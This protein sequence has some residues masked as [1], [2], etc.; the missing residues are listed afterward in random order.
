MTNTA[1]CWDIPQPPKVGVDIQ[2]QDFCWNDASCAAANNSQKGTDRSIKH[3]KCRNCL[4]PFGFFCHMTKTDCIKTAKVFNNICSACTD[5][6]VVRP[7]WNL[8]V[9]N[10]GTPI[11]YS[12]VPVIGNKHVDRQYPCGRFPQ[13]KDPNATTMMM[14]QPQ[15]QEYYEQPTPDQIKQHLLQQKQQNGST[16]NNDKSNAATSSIKIEQTNNKNLVSDAPL[17]NNVKSKAIIASQKKP[18]HSNKNNKNDDDDEY[19]EEDKLL[20]EG[21][22]K[23][24]GKEKRESGKR[25]G[26]NHQSSTDDELEN[27]NN[28]KNNKNKNNKKKQDDFSSGD[29]D[30]DSSDDEDQPVGKKKK[31]GKKPK[32]ALETARNIPI[33]PKKAELQMQI[34]D[35]LNGNLETRTAKMKKLQE[36][37][38]DDFKNAILFETTYG[39]VEAQTL[40]QAVHEKLAAVRSAF[41][42]HHKGDNAALLLKE[43]VG[44]QCILCGEFR[45]GSQRRLDQEAH[46][47]LRQQ[48]AQR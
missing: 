38:A 11:I 44:L 14:Q 31:K 32:V 6:V 43:A 16:T 17:Q 19:D 28:K 34:R 20:L 48:G 41:F 10:N 26:R 8:Q 7:Q 25:R 4:K 12:S 39:A 40:P 23:K 33:V 21:E 37:N 5:P 3:Q 45:I 15:P 30:Q 27:N 9:W 29:D 46:R 1:R 13:P 42:N 22:N 35:T 36:E 18:A 47:R 24:K 2:P